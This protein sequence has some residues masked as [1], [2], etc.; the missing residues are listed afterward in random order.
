M[1]RS[2]GDIEGNDD[3][4]P[5]G[6]EGAPEPFA[7]IPTCARATAEAINTDVLNMRNIL[8]LLS[9]SSCQLPAA[10][11]QLPVASLNVNLTTDWKPVRKLETIY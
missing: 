2:S 5:A 3:P 11:C 1:A 9:L 6:A 4:P 7:K 10:S 8:L